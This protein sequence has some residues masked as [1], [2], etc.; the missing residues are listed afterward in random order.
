[1]KKKEK[2]KEWKKKLLEEAAFQDR[3]P[4]E[5]NLE[6]TPLPPVIKDIK[7]RLGY[8]STFEGILLNQKDVKKAIVDVLSR[9]DR[10]LRIEELL[11]ELFKMGIRTKINILEEIIFRFAREKSLFVKKGYISLMRPADTK[12][13][14]EILKTIRQQKIITFNELL[15][16]FEDRKILEIILEDLE[17]LG[18]IVRDKRTNRIF[19]VS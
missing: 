9:A 16:T 14:R 4:F 7:R 8:P 12:L 18:V 3:K 1:L 10:P 6:K 17:S 15:S 2:I 13:G 5:I 19:I 11:S